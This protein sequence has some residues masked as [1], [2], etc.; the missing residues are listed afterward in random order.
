MHP[1]FLW[2]PTPSPVGAL[3][4]SQ[5]WTGVPSFSTGVPTNQS[6][7]Q[8]PVQPTQPL[9]QIDPVQQHL[10]GR[11]ASCPQVL[12]Q[13]GVAKPG[14]AT[15]ELFG[16]MDAASGTTNLTLAPPSV[17]TPWGDSSSY[18]AADPWTNPG[19][20]SR[21]IRTIALDSNT[22]AFKPCSEQP[23]TDGPCGAPIAIASLVSEDRLGGDD[24][25][26]PLSTQ[27]VTG[28]AFADANTLASAGSS[29]HG[30][31]SCRPCAWVWK[32][33]GCAL[34]KACTYCHSC[35][36]GEL[37]RRKKEKIAAM[38]LADSQSKRDP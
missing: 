21:M 13:A 27:I 31:G 35:P 14:G 36:E 9:Q 25:V 37:K 4:L 15:F 22:P 10:L 5:G 16:Q 3:H 28:G 18:W 23:P 30:S 33:N 34:G 11:N 6:M 8:V 24:P 26:K 19:S 38:R 7:E 2:P 1:S 32:A 12:R 17:R 29:Q 20:C